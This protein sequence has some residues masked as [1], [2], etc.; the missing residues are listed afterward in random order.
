MLYNLIGN[1]IN[2]TGDDKT[3]TVYV[4]RRDDKV[5]F[6]VRDTGKGIAPDEIDSVWERYYRA[7]QSKRKSVG[8]GL[9]LSIVKNILSLHGAEY[10]IQSALGEGSLFWFSMPSKDALSAVEN[11][12]PDKKKKK[13]KKDRDN[14]K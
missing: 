6:G 11:E 2:Y 4:K 5:Y 12:T 1:A 14:A 13:R 9:G 3:V 8:S 7:S 10:G